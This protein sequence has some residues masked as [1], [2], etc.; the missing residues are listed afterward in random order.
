MMNMFLTFDPFFLI[1]WNQLR[2]VLNI[3]DFGLNAQLCCFSL[4]FG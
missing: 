1:R 3:V 4:E 2:L